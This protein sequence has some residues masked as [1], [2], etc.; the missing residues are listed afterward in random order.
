MFAYE[1]VEQAHGILA[2]SKGPNSGKR[3]IEADAI[4]ARSGPSDI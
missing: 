3:A 1:I 4:E 2:T